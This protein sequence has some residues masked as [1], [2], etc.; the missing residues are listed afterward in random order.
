MI[1]EKILKKRSQ[2]NLLRNLR[3]HSCR[4]PKS[5]FKTE[6]KNGGFSGIFAEIPGRIYEGVLA[7][8]L[9]EFLQ[10]SQKKSLT[11]YQDKSG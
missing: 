10:D 11:K 3:K 9:D 2:E 5:E 7:G 6:K 8:I 4:N 1:F